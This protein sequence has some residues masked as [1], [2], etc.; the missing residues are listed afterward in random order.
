[1]AAYQRFGTFDVACQTYDP[2]SVR[3]IPNTHP[4]SQSWSWWDGI[5]T[6]QNDA[7]KL[8]WQVNDGTTSK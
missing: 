3:Y 4:T 2:T 8:V 7:G 1:M 5:G 6:A